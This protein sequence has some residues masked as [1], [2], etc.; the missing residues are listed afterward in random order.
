MVPETLKTQHL[1]KAEAEVQDKG[2]LES[3]WLE[4]EVKKWNVVY[5]KT[6]SQSPEVEKIYMY[7]KESLIL[8][9]KANNISFKISFIN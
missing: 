9:L 4:Q 1:R 8:D 3:F 2:I 6:F 7:I 5:L